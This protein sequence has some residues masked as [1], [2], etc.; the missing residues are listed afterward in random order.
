[1]NARIL[2]QSIMPCLDERPRAPLDHV[3]VGQDGVTIRRHGGMKSLGHEQVVMKLQGRV[4]EDVG[5]E[6]AFAGIALD[7]F[8]GRADLLGLG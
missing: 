6:G 7:D 5:I 4:H 1:M 8:A 2:L 3:V